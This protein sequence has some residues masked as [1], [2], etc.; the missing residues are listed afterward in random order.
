MPLALAIGIAIAINGYARGPLRLQCQAIAC[1]FMFLY[2]AIAI[3]MGMTE[4]G[5]GEGGKRISYRDCD[6]MS[7]YA[8]ACHSMPFFS[9][10][11]DFVCHGK[12]M[13][14]FFRFLLVWFEARLRMPFFYYVVV[15]LFFIN[16]V[17]DGIVISILVF[18]AMLFKLSAQRCL[19]PK[20][21]CC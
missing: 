14:G 19:S 16:I 17:Q 6:G 21:R 8:V 10:I 2:L 3:K 18:E 12:S 7:S 9:F 4:G 11:L 15:V 20:S 5:E 13:H 1:L